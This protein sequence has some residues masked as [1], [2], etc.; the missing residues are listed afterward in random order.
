MKK[1]ETTNCFNKNVTQE[2][3]L[4]LSWLAIV[5][6]SLYVHCNNSELVA[7][8][9]WKHLHVFT[10]TLIFKG[11][12]PNSLITAVLHDFLPILDMYFK[13]LICNFSHKKF[14]SKFSNLKSAF[15]IFEDKI[16]TVPQISLPYKTIGSTVCSKRC[17]NVFNLGVMLEKH[18]VSLNWVLKALLYKSSWQY[19]YVPEEEN[20][21]PK[22]LY[23]LL[24]SICTSLK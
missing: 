11:Y 21:M 7:N 10:N 4:T 15:L 24:F 13:N 1:S 8:N 6:L 12:L 3:L 9:R 18:F 16:F 2:T 5:Q 17:S 14:S 20:T 23:E 19:L 22:Y